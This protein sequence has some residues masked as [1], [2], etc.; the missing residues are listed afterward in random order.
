M[1]R[2]RCR[3]GLGGVCTEC[4]E[5]G[6]PRENAMFVVISHRHRLQKSRAGVVGVI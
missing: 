5:P 1:R 4:Q 2:F 3:F 6:E